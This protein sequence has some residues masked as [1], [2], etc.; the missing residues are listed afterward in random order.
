M[1]IIIVLWPDC[2]RNASCLNFPLIADA[3]MSLTSPCPQSMMAGKST[4]WMG[5]AVVETEVITGFAWK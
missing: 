5:R 3:T 4:S 1:F 2:T